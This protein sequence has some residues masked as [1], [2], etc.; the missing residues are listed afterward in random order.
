[1]G[2]QAARPEEDTDIP[3]VA[4]NLERPEG[5]GTEL[6][7]RRPRGSFTREV[8]PYG[9]ATLTFGENRLRITAAVTGDKLSFNLSADADYG[10][11]P[12]SMVYGVITG[13]DVETLGA[14][15]EKTAEVALMAGA[16]HDIPFAFRVRVEDDAVTVKDI[17]FGPFGSVLFIEA[18]GGEIP[19]L[20][21]MNV[22]AA[23]LGGKYK[24]DANPF[25]EQPTPPV[26]GKGR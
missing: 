16:V 2:K 22:M 12:E 11:N 15:D 17:K 13:V 21:E 23:A 26:K 14:K 6:V 1:M 9:R 7:V 10:V 3:P 25:R 24:S 18:L 4:P 19:H 5:P 20:K 8:A